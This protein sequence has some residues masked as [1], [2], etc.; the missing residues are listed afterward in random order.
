M[1]FSIVI[2]LF[3]LPLHFYYFLFSFGAHA[4]TS[5]PLILSFDITPSGGQLERYWPIVSNREAIAVNQQWA[6]EWVHTW[7]WSCWSLIKC[8]IESAPLL[9]THTHTHTHTVTHTHTHT[10]PYEHTTHNPLTGSVGS[11]IRKWNPVHDN[12]S[13]PLYAW[14]LA[15]NSPE[16]VAQG[17]RWNVHDTT[18]AVTIT[19]AHGKERACMPFRDLDFLPEGCAMQLVLP[20]RAHTHTHTHTSKHHH[21]HHHSPPPPPPPPLSPPPPPR[22]TTTTTT[23]HPPPPPPVE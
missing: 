10:H 8:F 17:R 16:V 5:S 14:G 18:G 13:S 6:G 1:I 15:C 11:L 19:T 4:V 20:K 2:L 21:H 3:S 23:H 9:Y 22:T 7:S 12:A